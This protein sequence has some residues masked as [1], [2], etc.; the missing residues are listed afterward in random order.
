MKH[1][2][3]PSYSVHSKFSYLIGFFVILLSFLLLQGTVSHKAYALTY[4]NNHFID[5]ALLLNANAMS[6]DTIQA[7]LASKSGTLKSMNFLMDCNV[8][9]TTAKQM[10]LSIGAPCGQMVSAARIIYYSGQVYGINPEIIMATLQ[11]EQS[12]I[13]DP[14]P[15]SWSYNQA[16]GYACPD[17]GTCSAAS[18][19]FYQIDNGAWDLRYLY[20][21]ANGNN[22]WW[23]TSAWACGTAKNYY[24]PNLYPN[25]NVKFFDD[26][27]TMYATVFIENAATS[28]L[29]CYTPHAYNNPQALYGRPAFGTTGMYY[30]GSYNFVYYY[31]LWFGST[32]AFI[33]NGISYASV[34]DPTYYVN[35]NLD[36]KSVFGDNQIAAFNHFVTKGMNE[37]RQASANFNVTSYRN[38]YADL[39]WAFGTTLPAYYAHFATTGNAEGRVATGNVTLLPVTT[40]GGIDYSNVY[41]FST[42]LTNNMDIKNTFSNDDTGALVHFVTKGM[43]EGRQASANF[44]VASYMGRYP[45]LRAALGTTNLRAYYI[46]FMVSGKPEGRIAT[47]NYLGGTTVF[48]KTDYSAIYGFDYYEKNN[49]D[50]QKTFGL[51]DSAALQHF[52]NTGMSEGRQGSS[53]FSVYAYKARYPD[54]VQ[55]FGNNLKSY[56]IHYLNYGKAEGRIG[57]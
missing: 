45:D 38:R 10:Y 47:G 42:Y 46:H 51:N 9:G 25:Q 33:Y 44:N 14:A 49:S 34:F 8:A 40:F 17:S 1:I 23:N 35:N 5:N 13:T 27:G 19:F 43:N 31:D 2:T 32:Y 18:D 26:N 30:T 21:R 20:E 53:D 56:Y 7:F 15:T 11:K 16:M 57:T 4:T 28:A 48:N 52:I 39:R 12:L 36:L 3:R 29:Y 50:I 41:D 6:P 54:L 37:G 55:A 22:T 24:T